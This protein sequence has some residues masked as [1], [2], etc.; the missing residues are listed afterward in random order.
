MYNRPSGRCVRSPPANT[1]DLCIIRLCPDSSPG[2]KH[3]PAYPRRGRSAAHSPTT[4]DPQQRENREN[5][6]LHT[7]HPSESSAKGGVHRMGI[8]NSWVTGASLLS[9][10]A[11]HR[12]VG[13]HETEYVQV[14]NQGRRPERRTKRVGMSGEKKRGPS[15]PAT[16]VC[17]GARSLLRGQTS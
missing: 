9:G 16:G 10:L 1:L 8:P 2:R 13:Q 15:P 6:Q 17:R 12:G 7:D 4:G 5:S 11:C 3:T 14:Q